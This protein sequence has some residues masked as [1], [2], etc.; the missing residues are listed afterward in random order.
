MKKLWRN[1]KV[2]V[3]VGSLAIL[4][5]AYKMGWL[6]KVLSKVGITLPALPF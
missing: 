5:G 3:I 2:A 6:Q 1:N 4:V